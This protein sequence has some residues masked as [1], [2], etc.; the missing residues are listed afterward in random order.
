MKYTPKVVEK[1]IFCVRGRMGTRVI[2][3]TPEIKFQ[4]LT[5]QGSTQ[6]FNTGL[7]V[8]CRQLRSGD[9]KSVVRLLG[10]LKNG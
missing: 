4:G 6:L 10:E 1:A 3:V 5:G 2:I 7:L 8:Q 9:N